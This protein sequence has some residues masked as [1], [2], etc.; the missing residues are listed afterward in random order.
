MIVGGDIQTDLSTGPKVIEE[1]VHPLGV[2]AIVLYH[3]ARAANDFPSI[4]LLVDLAEASPR[5]YR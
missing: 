2:D 5:S 1:D 4:T 3:D